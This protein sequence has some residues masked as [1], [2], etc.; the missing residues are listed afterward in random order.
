MQYIRIEM[1][2]EGRQLMKERKKERKKESSV[3]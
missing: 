2:E 3:K 1:S